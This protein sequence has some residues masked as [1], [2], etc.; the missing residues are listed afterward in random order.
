MPEYK[1]KEQKVKFYKS[2]A[3][4]ELRLKALERDHYECQECK[5]Q[6]MVYT[7]QHDPD[8]HKRLDVDHMKEIYTHPE[9]AL[10]I[11]NLETLC[12]KCHNKK[13]GRFKYTPKQN[14][15]NDEKW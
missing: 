2:D 1:T 3:W 6:G 5:R 10:E 7:D 9:L 11:D 12:I 4:Q 13:H 15:W 14:R 8:K